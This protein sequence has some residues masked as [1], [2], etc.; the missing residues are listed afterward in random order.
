[1]LPF[2]QVNFGGKDFTREIPR[3]DCETRANSLPGRLFLVVFTSDFL[4]ASSIWQLYLTCHRTQMVVVQTG[5][6]SPKARNQCV[7]LDFPK[8][9][10]VARREL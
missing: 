5:M 7:F 8:K 10:S 1:M 6:V 3:S 2:M 9:V 4:R